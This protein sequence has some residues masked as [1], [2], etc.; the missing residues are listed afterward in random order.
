[1]LAAL[2]SADGYPAFAA[3]RIFVE[4][5][6]NSRD[7]LVPTLSP[8]S[9]VDMAHSLELP[10]AQGRLMQLVHGSNA[11]YSQTQRQNTFCRGHE[12]NTRTC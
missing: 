11:E 10:P 6:S 2:A 8:L 3:R 5:D 9:H 12:R 7:R 1:M 4:S